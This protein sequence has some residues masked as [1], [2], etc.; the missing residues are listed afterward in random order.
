MGHGRTNSC[1]LVLL[2]CGSLRLTPII[3]A[4]LIPPQVVK[5]DSVA[6]VRVLDHATHL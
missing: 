4:K 5:L 1:T 3:L 6:M 2:M